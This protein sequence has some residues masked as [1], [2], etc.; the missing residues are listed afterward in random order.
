MNKSMNKK[1]Y[2]NYI[3]FLMASNKM[4]YCSLEEAWGENYANLYK[5]DDNMLTSMPFEDKYADS[6][7]LK[8]RN[9]TNV[10]TPV[11]KDNIEEDLE[12]FYNSK[13]QELLSSPLES[14]QRSQ[15]T[16]GSDLC[17]TLDCQKY[18]EHFLECENCK[19]KVNTILDMNSSNRD[20]KSL[21]ENF[22]LRSNIDEGY[23]DIL[24]LVL[25]GIFIIFILDCFI[26]LGRNFR[27]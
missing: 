4:S 14:H 11:D 22:N 19:K 8:D 10:S 2:G 21:I 26:R 3:L 12:K 23:L 5:K 17:Q 20:N 13:K 1:I 15:G 18:L 25:L 16:Q 27:R 7:L 6:T 9:L 24:V